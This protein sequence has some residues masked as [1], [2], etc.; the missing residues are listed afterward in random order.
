MLLW[1][2]GAL[3]VIAVSA[4]DGAQ[5][6]PPP[7]LKNKRDTTPD[8]EFQSPTKG[9]FQQR[10]GGNGE[11]AER[12]RR[13]RQRME[14]MQ[15]G[16]GPGE[17]PGGNGA[18]PGNAGGPGPGGPEGQGLRGRGV[19]GG[20]SGGAGGRGMSMG[21]PFGIGGSGRKQLDLTPLNL[22]EQQKQQI[23]QSRQ[24]T[25]ERMRDTKQKVTERQMA[26]REM[27]FSPDASEAQIKAARKQLREAQNQM[28]EISLDDLLNIRRV[29]T[30]EQRQKLPEIAPP[31][32]SQNQFG[33]RGGTTIG[34]RRPPQE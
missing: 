3:S 21:T 9:E 31:I 34:E 26:L 16:G 18:G 1:G 28:D 32:P 23:K 25:R 4:Q 19:G 8:P 33:P 6:P 12:R 10:A 29:L 15:N 24:S 11:F 5:I 27:I 30:A 2:L 17:G 13:M 22:T 20:G 14:Q 7:A